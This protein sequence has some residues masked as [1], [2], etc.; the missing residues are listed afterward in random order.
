METIIKSPSE[1]TEIE[2]STFVKM[3]EEGGQVSRYKIR[4]KVERAQKLV[5]I[6]NDDDC[7]A[8]AALKNP[9]TS[10]KD[11]V[12]K[13]AGLSEKKDLYSFEIGY[14]YAT[15][16][17]VGNLLMQAVIGANDGASTFATTRDSNAAMQH[18]LP[19]FGFK[20][21][22]SSYKNESGEYLLALFGNEK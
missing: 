10:Y 9:A 20:K 16:K 11:K 2:I 19:K 18:L 12:F 3:I 22:G 6:W 13:A 1:C 17:G 15:V 7:V 21:L 14:I 4:E 5:F 8:I